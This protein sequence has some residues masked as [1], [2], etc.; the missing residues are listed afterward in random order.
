MGAAHPGA[1]DQVERAA[2]D[3]EAAA[4]ALPRYVPQAAAVRVEGSGS[5]PGAAAASLL[6]HVARQHAPNPAS[7][8]APTATAATAAA[9]AAAADAPLEVAALRAV[10]VDHGGGST[11]H[12][13]SAGAAVHA[14]AWLPRLGARRSQHLAV[15][16]HVEAAKLRPLSG[17]NAIQLWQLALQPQESRRRPPPSSSR[18][19]ATSPPA[20]SDED[21]EEGAAEGAEGTEG[22]EGSAE[23]AASAPAVC[24]AL[25]MHS[26]GGVLDLAWCPAGNAAEVPPAAPPEPSATAPLASQAE[27]EAGAGAGAGAGTSSAGAAAGIPA[28]S[29]AVLT[30]LGLLAAAC[31]DG[32]VRLFAVPTRDAVARLSA[33]GAPARAPAPP[34]VW[35]A[36]ALILTAP[37]SRLAL[38]LAWSPLPPYAQ[39]AVGGD[40]GNITLWQLDAPARARGAEVR[41]ARFVCGEAEGA[42]AIEEA[43]Q[44]GGQ[45]EAEE[46][47]DGESVEVH[48]PAM[49]FGAAG[50]D[51][52]EPDAQFAL[53]RARQ[54]V[55]NEAVSHTGPVRAL[56]WAPPPGALLA[57]AAHDRSLM[58]WEVASS[59]VRHA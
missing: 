35:L 46:L 41:A 7:G 1:L 12:L 53:E 8:R 58:V 10:Q 37:T 59:W 45:A 43:G 54:A 36:P 18:R 23:G 17:P 42:G 15:G 2:E 29:S 40:N 52:A 22:A 13:A 16:T 48:V 19:R 20:D 11:A 28:S 14:V 9:A 57:S 30:R 44:A 5:A 34:R 24:W 56:A 47:L 26:G 4:P 3:A 21:P 31:A 51:A 27:A 6:L 55:A 39:L 25:L 50:H 33:A 38:C 32:K 49:I